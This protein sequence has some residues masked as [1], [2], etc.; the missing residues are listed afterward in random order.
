MTASVVAALLSQ[1]EADLRQQADAL[2]AVPMRAHKVD[3]FALLGIHAG[4][5]LAVSPAEN[6]DCP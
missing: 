2:Q 6:V 5:S 3:Q 4:R 1:I